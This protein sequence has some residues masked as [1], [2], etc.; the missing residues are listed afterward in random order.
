MT[1][2]RR[3]THITAVG[4]EFSD[5][6]YAVCDDNSVWAI[7][8]FRDNEWIRLPSPPPGFDDR[9]EAGDAAD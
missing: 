2:N 7:G 9:A 8:P 4:S 3:I 6:L 1:H 5:S